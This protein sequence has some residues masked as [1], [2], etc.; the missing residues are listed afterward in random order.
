MSSR[1]RT[2]C[3]VPTIH[4]RGSKNANYCFS[5]IKQ[6]FIKHAGHL[7]GMTVMK[8]TK[9]KTKTSSCLWKAPLLSASLHS[10]VSCLFR[11]PNSIPGDPRDQ[12]A[13][14]RSPHRPHAGLLSQGRRRGGWG[15]GKKAASWRAD[16][17]QSQPYIN[18]T[19]N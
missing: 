15:A 10:P 3:K 8:N 2:Q 17:V 12:A 19:Q 4:R 16:P 1:T 9:T 5:F 11:C 7:L 6:P 14:P 13:R 18:T